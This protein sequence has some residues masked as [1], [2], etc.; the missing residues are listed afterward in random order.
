MFKFLRQYQNWI[1]AVGV[2][3]LMLVF[4]IEVPLSTS[5][6]GDAESQAIGT[7]NGEK[8]RLGDQR[9]AD[10][11]INV[12]GSINQLLAQ[13]GGSEK[14]LQWLL[15][16]REARSMGLD[17]SRDQIE[18]LK[19]TFL[20]E[21]ET[22][23]QAAAK[24][25]VSMGTIDT[26]IRHWGMVQQMQEMI[27]GLGH[28]AFNERIAMYGQAMQF[29]QMGY[30]PGAMMIL[31]GTRG[32][33][34]VSEPLLL[35]FVQ[36]QQAT[37][38]IAAL[39]I[40]AERYLSQ[41]KTVPDEIAQGLFDKY[42]DKLPGE[43]DSA[44]PSDPGYGLGYKSPDRVRLEYLALPYDRLRAKIDVDEADILTYY[45][46]NKAEFRPAPPE[47]GATQ[48]AAAP[49][50]PASPDDAARAKIIDRLKDQRANDLANRA[51]KLAQ[52]I[53]SEE[54]RKLKDEGGYRVVPADFK[55]VSLESVAQQVQKQFGILPDVR[56]E[57]DRWLG[58]SD[59]P[60]LPGVGRSAANGRQSEPFA[61]YVLSAKEMS[62]K[63]DNPLVALRLQV[64][65]ASVPTIGIDQSRYLF[66]LIAAEPARV[67]A[68][69]DEVRE[70]VNADARRLA[71]FEL[72]KKDTPRWAERLQKEKLDAI[73]KEIGRSVI[74]PA[75][76]RRRDL[77][78]GGQA[79]QIDGVGRD[80]K[81]VDSVFALAREAF[82]RGPI[83]SAPAAQRSRAIASDASMALYLVRVD[84]FKAIT[85]KDYDRMASNPLLV[86]SMQQLIAPL[87]KNDDP[88]TIAAI[89]KRLGFV[90]AHAEKAEEEPA[91]K[92]AKS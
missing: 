73:A 33:P 23:I 2:T 25:G 61:A 4:L 59:L 15:M 22:Q 89:K 36:E 11:E 39:A 32:K 28:L 3:M 16:V 64:G 17:V 84:G 44:S 10:A 52:S 21:E 13:G 7:I 5:F 12:L 72:L 42:R 77:N 80:A 57:D 51:F 38:E 55:P 45:D 49:A 92:P 78:A 34:R 53:L 31:E 62:P 71:A 48:P 50:D 46:E 81:F 74:T 37:V 8:I 20:G 76:C 68:S 29:A 66:R 87:E 40:P 88:F 85:R 6:R 82:A 30:M 90:S 26:A 69:L 27:L 70:K 24:L 75:P 79:P 56:R 43:T 83:E 86:G 1:L 60:L 41:V 63:S 35:H 65:V 19:H 54:V 47:P 9:A 14:A 67:P 58:A 91:P 18:Q